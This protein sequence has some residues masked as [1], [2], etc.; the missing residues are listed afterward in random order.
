MTNHIKPAT[1]SDVVFINAAVDRLRRAR[2]L[3]AAAGA[4]K[5][6]AAARRAIKSADG[7]RRHVTHRLARTS[8]ESANG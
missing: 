3:L 1:E 2:D 4:T 6:A 5:A 8:K 7:A